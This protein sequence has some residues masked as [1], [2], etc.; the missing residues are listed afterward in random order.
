[1]LLPAHTEA[2][3][4]AGAGLSATVTVM[5]LVEKQAALIG[6]A[7]KISG[8]RSRCYGTVDQGIGA[9]GGIGQYGVERERTSG[10]VAR[11]QGIQVNGV[12]STHRAAGYCKHGRHTRWYRARALLH[13]RRHRTRRAV[14]VG[15]G[16]GVKRPVRAAVLEA[17]SRG[18]AVGDAGGRARV[19]VPPPFTVRLYEAPRPVP[20]GL[21]LKVM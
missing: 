17:E 9:C 3:F 4:T 12:A 21:R 1:M 16:D 10:G 14:H 2:L 6:A 5:L 11:Y 7:H 20:V 18:R 8:G 19:T 13:R 15:D